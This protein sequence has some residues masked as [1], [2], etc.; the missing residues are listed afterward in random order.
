MRACARVCVCV[1]ACVCVCVRVCVCVCVCVYPADAARPLPPSS[2]ATTGHCSTTALPPPKTPGLPLDPQPPQA[3]ERLSFE[4]LSLERRVEGSNLP[5]PKTL[6]KSLLNMAL[7]PVRHCAPQ[8][9]LTKRTRGSSCNPLRRLGAA[10]RRS[11]QSSTL[12]P[13]LP[14]WS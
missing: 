8:S 2:L 6:I 4:V 11:Q 10:G 9:P 5:L 1:C 3:P 13:P 7:P 12:T 14:S